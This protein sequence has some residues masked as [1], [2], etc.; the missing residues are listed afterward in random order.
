MSPAALPQSVA[1]GRKCP[2]T[3]FRYRN[4]EFDGIPFIQLLIQRKYTPAVD[5]ETAPTRTTDARQGDS[6]AAGPRPGK[7]RPEIGRDAARLTGP[8]TGVSAGIHVK[9]PGQIL[10]SQGK[11]ARLPRLSEGDPTN[12]KAI[13][14]PEGQR[15]HA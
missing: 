5:A 8:L 13:A 9:A 7:S 11:A 12:A 10:R 4:A 6:S 15:P 1:G 2:F 14:Q 3:V